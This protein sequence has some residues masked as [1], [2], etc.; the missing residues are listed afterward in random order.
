VGD[1]WREFVLRECRNLEEEMNRFDPLKSEV[2]ELMGTWRE[3]EL[4]GEGEMGRGKGGEGRR[5][6]EEEKRR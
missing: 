4:E 5:D 6:C 1:V 2:K 3:L